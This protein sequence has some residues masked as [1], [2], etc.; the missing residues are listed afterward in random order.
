MRST[1]DV[2]VILRLLMIISMRMF[3]TMAWLNRGSTSDPSL[4]PTLLQHVDQHFHAHVENRG[5]DEFGR[6]F[7]QIP[8][9]HVIPQHSSEPL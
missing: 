7:R 1:D 4:L 5:I 8:H 2:L 3:S 9:E 6:G